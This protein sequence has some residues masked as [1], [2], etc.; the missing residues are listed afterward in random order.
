MAIKPFAIQGSDL[1]L[2]GVNLQAGATT[3][4]IPG[5]TQAV[6]YFV[7]EVDERDGNNPDTFGSDAGAITV[8]DN[9]RWLAIT[10]GNN[11]PSADYV[12]ATYSVNE[13]DDGNIEE[14]TVETAGVFL[15][16]DKTRAEAADM[17][18]TLQPT[19]FTG[20]NSAN[21]TQI[22]FRPKIRAGEV[23]NI[24][25]GGGTTL[26]SQ[27]GQTGKF[28][29]T[30]GSALSWS[31]PAGGEGLPTIT[32]PAETGT[33]YK[34][35]QV[36]YGGFHTH[37]NQSSTRNVTKVVIHKPAVTTTTITDD[38]NT[39]L[40]QVSGVGTSDILAL[41]VVFGDINGEKPLSD[42][43]A[44]AEAVIDN[45]ILDD[46]VEGDYQSVNAMKA[47]F[48]DNYPSLASAANGLAVDFQFFTTAP[49]L[50][51]GVTTVRE[52]YGALFD[53][54]D[55][56]NGTYSAGILNGGTDYL[57]GHKIKILGTALG[58]ATPDN[59]IIIRVEALTS[60]SISS[61][62]NTGTA[63]GTETDTYEG[64]AGTNYDVGSGFT[65]ESIF[66]NVDYVNHSSYGTNYVVGDVITLLGENLTNGTTP[67][68]NFTL[69][70]TAVDG[71]GQPFQYTLSGT[72]PDV[73]R[74][75]SIDDGGNDEYDTGNYIDSSYDTQIDYNQGAT[76]SDGVAA[77]GTGSSY[78]F[79]Y[80]AGI[81]GLFVTGNSSTSI[82]TSGSGPDSGSTI[83]SGNIYGPNIAEQTFDNAVTHI[84]LT[85][86]SYAGPLITF[87]KPDNTNEVD[88]VSDGLHIA[89]DNGG[90]WLYNPQ[91][92]EGHGSSSPYN[93]LWNN[94]GWDDFSN[95]ESRN[96][97]SLSTIWQGR[98]LQIT[99]AKMIM[100]D[101]STDKYWAVEILSWG[102]DGGFSYTRREL[103]LDGLAAGIRFADGTR[104]TTA[105]VPLDTNVISTAPNNRRIETA[106]GYKQVA[107]TEKIYSGSL[108]AIATGSNAGSTWQVVVTKTTELTAFYNS[109]TPVRLEVSVNG[110]NWYPAY[111]GGSNETTY[112]LIFE[113]NVPLPLD[114][115][116]VINYRTYTG[117]DS[118]VWWDKDDLPGGSNDFRGAIIDYHAYTSSGTIVGTIH[119]IDD[120]G[121]EYITHTEVSSADNNSSMYDNLWIVTSEGEI[122]YAR[123]DGQ[124]K[125]L[126]IHWT[127]RV[128]Y[129]SDYSDD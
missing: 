100:K 87:I 37:V 65:V 19:P 105:Y 14:I 69:T 20:F 96:Y 18:A 59:D 25:G 101:T 36:A 111:I 97:V 80:E 42:I 40:F 50:N 103:D 38:S 79:V 8:I 83:I 10:T 104:Q 115:G 98:F 128:F 43:Q 11:T 75:N 35:L 102:Y 47:A 89:R 129:G 86:D 91:E 39:D 119:I 124:A 110:T 1:T 122:R 31:T 73:W 92:D 71:L 57:P 30:D 62:S 48:Y 44:F 54:I 113:N 34:G 121:D 117:G 22:P 107:V 5:V 68:N 13:L 29:K 106:S 76:V 24:G 84:N 60:S 125:T 23:E 63:A 4:V 17:W 61:I 28:L 26:P 85:S 32:V 33:T 3:I 88:E 67:E 114:I 112:Q 72:I 126:R 93:S 81:F 64:L 74:T 108:E 70:V 56:G 58:G 7:E 51:G 45:V 95:V 123:L 53:I 6:D 120:D 55:N 15:A 2:G 109:Q 90:G 116:D 9:S 82:G 41:F 77:F 27:S 94:D 127:A 16:A 66:R 118:V 46:G 78:S 52:G 21:W 12:A 49:A 99:G